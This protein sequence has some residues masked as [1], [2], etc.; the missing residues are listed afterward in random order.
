MYVLLVITS[1]YW[2]GVVTMQEFSSFDTC[3][4]AKET[5]VNNARKFARDVYAVCTVK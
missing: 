1:V 3:N 2:G 5:I 4:L